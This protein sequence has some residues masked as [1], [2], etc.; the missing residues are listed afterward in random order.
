MEWYL[1]LVF[2]YIFKE[3]HRDKIR[4]DCTC[5]LT[6]LSLEI[7]GMNARFKLAAISRLAVPV[8]VFPNT[9]P[10]VYLSLSLWIVDKILSVLSVF[11]QPDSDWRDTDTSLFQRPPP[12]TRFLWASAYTLA[13][14]FHLCLREGVSLAS[15]IKARWPLLVLDGLSSEGTAEDQV[16]KRDCLFFSKC[17]DAFQHFTS[18][19]INTHQC[20]HPYL[21]RTFLTYRPNYFCMG[22]GFLWFNTAW[23]GIELGHANCCSAHSFLDVS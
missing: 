11:H 23:N 20:F 16:V 19:T 8:A 14:S 18:C 15:F 7:R 3:N 5:R 9:S 1:A 21:D 17:N 12:R 22:D 6:Q 2:L 13:V 10:P 4:R